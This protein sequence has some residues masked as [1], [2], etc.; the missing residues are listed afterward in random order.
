MSFSTYFILSF[1]TPSTDCAW[2]NKNGWQCEQNAITGPDSKKGSRCQ[3]SRSFINLPELSQKEYYPTFR[4]EPEVLRVPARRLQAYRLL[5][6]QRH[7]QEEGQRKNVA[8]LMY[9]APNVT[10]RR[11]V[12]VKYGNRTVHIFTI[13]GMS[14]LEFMM[15]IVIMASLQKKNQRRQRWHIYLILYISYI[16]RVLHISS[17]G[18]VWTVL[19]VRVQQGIHWWVK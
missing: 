2:C 7:L 13:S 15:K 11:K 14:V 16:Y 3:A 5:W 18:Q 17:G 19:A 10:L 4:D 9:C 1:L 6:S 8:D 12:N